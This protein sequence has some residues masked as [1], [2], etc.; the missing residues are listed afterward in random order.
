MKYIA[1][2]LFFQT[3][4]HF[5]NGMLSETQNRFLAD[6]LFSGLCIEAN[7]MGSEKLGRFYELAKSGKIVFSDSFPFIG[8]TLYIPKPMM[9]IERENSDISVRKQWKKLQYLPIDAMEDYFSGN[10]NVQKENERLKNLGKKQV[11]QKVSL[12]NEEKSEPYTVGTF[13]FRKGNGLYFFMGYEKEE[14]KT[15]IEQF[16]NSLGY[17]GIG[18]KVS[19]GLGKYRAVSMELSDNIQ[20]RLNKETGQFVLL[21][22]S[23]PKE[24]EIESVL[25][26]ASYLIEKR[27]G[28]IQSESYAKE[29]VKKQEQYFLKSGSVVFKRYEGDVYNV[30]K[31]G[32]H[33]VFRYAKPILMEVSR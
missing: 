18:G 11:I 28:F 20:K 7:K 6:T 10:L 27:A 24:E 14:D 22:T 21:T 33:S 12:T 26:N 5:G 9:I 32:T 8:E 3:A 29:Y 23:L 13:H 31:N 15:F 16:I 19:S 1:Y 2:Q 17:Q 4:V 30:G 25:S